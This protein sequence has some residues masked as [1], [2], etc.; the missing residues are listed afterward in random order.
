AA[1]GGK[2]AIDVPGGKNLVGAF[3]WPARVVID[4]ALLETLADS[5]R[6]NG[7][8]EVVKTGLLIGEP[9][10]DLPEPVQVRRCAAFKSAV[11]LAD[12]NDRGIRNQLNVGHTFAHALE[13]AAGYELPHGEAVA[14]GLTAALQLTGRDEEIAVVRRILAPEPVVVDRDAAWAAL[15]RDKKAAKGSPRLVL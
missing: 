2:T 5:D 9:L 11:C 14:L 13:A 1:I 6:R 12:P 15:R 3:H 10:W 7:L 4:P 8:A